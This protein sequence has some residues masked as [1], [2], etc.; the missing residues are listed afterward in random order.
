MGKL[1]DGMDFDK[2]GEELVNGGM[3]M[4]RARFLGDD[5]VLLTPKE[6]EVMEDIMNIN[7][8]WFDSVFISIN[9]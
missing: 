9:P 8:E 5:L 1:G 2:F 4:V 7:K 6:G 3:S